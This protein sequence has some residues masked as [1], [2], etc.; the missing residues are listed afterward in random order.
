MTY[1]YVKS[2]F[3]LNS[4]K[5]DDNSDPLGTGFVIAKIEDGFLLVT[6]WHVVNAIGKENLAIR[7]QRCELFSTR[8]N[9]VLDLAVLK[10]KSL[11]GVKDED[12]KAL[13]WSKVSSSLLEHGTPFETVGFFK[14]KGKG[15]GE[16]K[17]NTSKSPESRKLDGYIGA[18]GTK[19]NV[20]SFQKVI[21][22]CDYYIKN[23]NDEKEFPLEN[24]EKGYSGS[25][26]IVSDQV[27]AV[28][29]H[30]KGGNIGKAIDISHIL[31]VCEYL[32]QL[33]IN[34]K[35]NQT[36]EKSDIEDIEDP[37]KIK[38]LYVYRARFQPFCRDHYEA[39]QGFWQKYVK[40]KVEYEKENSN[41]NKEGKSDADMAY[42]SD[43]AP[44]L[45]LWVVKRLSTTAYNM[46]K[47]NPDDMGK[48]FFRHLSFF[49]PFDY[50]LCSKVIR[51]DLFYF[52]DKD[53]ED[54]EQS[55]KEL[56]E[57]K[58]WAEVHLHIV[59]IPFSINEI[60][61]YWGADNG[62]I[63]EK[64]SS[65]KP[66]RGNS[67]FIEIFSNLYSD[68]HDMLMEFDKNK[69][70]ED[71]FYSDRSVSE[72]A[73]NLA[74]RFKDTSSGDEPCMFLPIFDAQDLLDIRDL[75]QCEWNHKVCY[76]PWLNPNFDDNVTKS[77]RYFTTQLNNITNVN[78]C[79]QNAFIYYV[80]LKLIEEDKIDVKVDGIAKKV[81]KL[82]TFLTKRSTSNTVDLFVDMVDDL[83]TKL[84]KKNLDEKGKLSGARSVI[85]TSL[86]NLELPQKSLINYNLINTV[87]GVL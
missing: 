5:E 78:L 73:L 72:I 83:I 86:D 40:P 49:N 55:K 36:G 9:D 26:I 11:P 47:V 71:C 45:Y 44:E 13:R 3:P 70:D 2:V 37:S 69:T 62:F 14:G 87:T 6:D 21:K 42:E 85:I 32:K 58:K 65:I 30:R 79:T 82:K 4:S 77:V 16:G 27:I 22:R 12:V 60:V 80:Y 54:Y 33:T 74:T 41:C 29:T 31:D 57:L 76:L 10:I 28:I 68:T 24:V 84:N 15:K 81:V 25:P 51:K 17:Y 19:D 46:G 56:V 53:M 59:S 7:G 35:E 50:M 67:K 43:K 66:N 1:D 8:G 39:I 52:I 34:A 61:L 75:E 38:D 23:K 20:G 48:E 18:L 63:Y 64:T